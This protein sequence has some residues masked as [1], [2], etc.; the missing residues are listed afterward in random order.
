MQNKQ[1]KAAPDSRDAP[2]YMFKG[3]EWEPT[4]IW[5]YSENGDVT[6]L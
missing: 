2:Q 6:V 5:R 1:I 3:N 4:D